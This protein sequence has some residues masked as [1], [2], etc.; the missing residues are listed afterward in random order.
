M[1]PFIGLRHLC[2][3][4]HGVI[5]Y[6]QKDGFRLLVPQMLRGEL[7]DR[8][9]I[10][11]ALGDSEDVKEMARFLIRASAISHNIWCDSV[12]PIFLGIGQGKYQGFTIPAINLR[13][14]TYYL[15]RRVFHSAR[16]QK[17]GPIVFQL[18]S[19][20]MD[21]TGQPPSEYVSCILAAAL[22]E[23]YSGPVFLQASRIGTRDQKTD[24]LD[25]PD[26]KPSALIADA[27]ASGI[28]NLE[29]ECSDDLDETVKLIS[30][31]RM[32]QPD[33][34]SI[35]V[36]CTIPLP[37]SRQTAVQELLGFVT[38]LKTRL[39]DLKINES[40]CKINLVCNSDPMGSDFLDQ[41]QMTGMLDFNRLGA[42]SE[43]LREQLGM[44]G[45]V[46]SSSHEIQA[47]FFDQVATYKISELKM[48]TWIQDLIL[49][50][51]RFP[52]G[53]REEIRAYLETEYTHLRKADWSDQH[54]YNNLRSRAWK[55]YKKTLWSLDHR[56]R[57][58]ISNSFEDRIKLLFENLHVGLNKKLVNRLYKKIKITPIRIPEGI[59]EL[60]A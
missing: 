13:G 31:I 37:K 4:M 24:S 25:L 38:G 28:F 39:Q 3:S 29:F 14:I 41:D 53:L 26:I 30:E 56:T 6:N 34:V 44:A 35:A 20:E 48:E 43:I 52:T 23:N 1:E 50:H 47:D 36:G 8:L 42:L 46:L 16:R 32:H 19:S 18:S 22:R 55:P 21:I 10:T 59:D 5:R 9:A 49:N 40:V 60:P 17:A 51:D 33:G 58:T 15:A 57:L 54:F 45:P 27:I 2:E 12:S 7:V 11:A